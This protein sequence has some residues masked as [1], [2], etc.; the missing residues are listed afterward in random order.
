MMCATCVGMY[1]YPHLNT[2]AYTYTFICVHC[3]QIHTQTGLAATSSSPIFQSSAYT[4]AASV[5]REELGDLALTARCL[6]CW[7]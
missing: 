2:Y 3:I 1:P 7:Q 6:A 4:H 5:L